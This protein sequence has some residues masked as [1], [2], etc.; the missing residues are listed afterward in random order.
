MLMALPIGGRIITPLHWKEVPIG[1]VVYLTA[2]VAI[3]EVGTATGMTEWITTHVFP[4]VLPHT[5]FFLVLLISV[6]CILLHLCLGSTITSNSVLIPSMLLCTQSTILPPI[7]C[8]MVC[9]I[10][11][12]GQF[13]F[14]YQHINILLGIGE[15]G[16]YTERDS[17]RMALPLTIG[18]PLVILL[19]GL[20]WWKLIGLL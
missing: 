5:L 3:G 2:A 9:Y 16:M 7:I 12:F 11:I 6:F 13:I 4:S 18:V 10:S 15:N 20:P 1:T 17:L 19:V 14:S 8:V